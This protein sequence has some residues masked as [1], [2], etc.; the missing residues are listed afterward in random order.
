MNKKRNSNFELMRIF[1]MFLIV[2]CHACPEGTWFKTSANFYFISSFRNWTG[3]LGNW[4][5]ILISGYFVSISSFSWKKIF[6]LWFQVFSISA[7]IGLILYFAKIPV[8]GYDNELY[9]DLGFFNAA[10]PMTKKDLLKAF[11]PT[12]LGHNWFAAAY[13]SFYFFVPFLNLSLKYL[14]KNTHKKIII[15]MILIGTV[16]PLVWFQFFFKADNLFYFILGFYIASYIRIYNPSFLNYRKNIII[17]F[18]ICIFF[19]LW[20]FAML[21]YGKYIPYVK[22]HLDYWANY[23]FSGFNKFPLLICAIF[24]FAFFRN[25]KMSYNKF[26]NLIASTTF[27]VYLIHENLLLKKVIWHR[28]FKFDAFIDKTYFIF[29][30]LFSVLLVFFM[31]S[32]LEIA[33]K[34]V[35][36]TPIA[37]I[38]KKLKKEH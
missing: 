27:G 36:E 31:C 35:I 34:K 24:L 16:L 28:L 14:D 15:T 33:R 38:V 29:Y 1:A 2:F 7:A 22:D 25:L 20:K 26:I 13:I 18:C 21:K 12:L 23:P 10:S 5:F 8:I 37:M 19:F 4:L 30:M 11:L 32:I 3:M 9:Q 6:K 17:S